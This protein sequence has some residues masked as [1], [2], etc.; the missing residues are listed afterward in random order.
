M[1]ADVDVGR[2]TRPSPR[3]HRQGTSR[4]LVYAGWVAGC[5]VVVSSLVAAVR[6]ESR[7]SVGD[8]VFLGVVEGVT[9]YLPVSS[10]G[11]LTVAE[12]LL[13]IGDDPVEK[14]AADSFTIVIQAGA[15]AAVALLYRQRLGQMIGSLRTGDEDHRRLGFAVLLA[16]VPAGVVGLVFGDVLKQHLLGVGP[17]AVAWFF[18]GVAILAL[19]RMSGRA[20]GRLED[21]QP[22]A[23]LSIGV[24]QVLAL[25]PGVSRSLVTILAA[26]AFGLSPAAAVEFSFLLGLV[27]LGAATAWEALRHGSDMVSQ[28]GVGTVLAGFATSTVSAA[29]SVQWLVS[30]LRRRSLTVFGWYRIVAACIAATLL[31]TGA[32]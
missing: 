2:G 5:I 21:L 10:T 12:R 27:T 9:E 30:Y 31:I 25:W 3:P 18:G 19:P 20:D 28:L 11:H 15:I 14:K 26:T 17:V 32:L 23:A 1:S 13:G 4:L 16:A 22:R 24:A 29:L 7:M 6:T 8:A